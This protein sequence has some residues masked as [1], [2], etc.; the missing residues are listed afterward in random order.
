MTTRTTTT[1][2]P[3]AATKT[4]AA[5]YAELSAIADKLRI[6]GQAATVDEIVDLLKAARAAHAVCRARLDTIRR[7]VDAELEAAES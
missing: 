4:Y 2:A 7:E 6:G 3:P 5:A 1:A